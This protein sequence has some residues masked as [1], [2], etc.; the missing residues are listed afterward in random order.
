MSTRV[1]TFGVLLALWGCGSSQP[2]SAVFATSGTGTWR[3]LLP[4]PTPYAENGDRDE[5]GADRVELRA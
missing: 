4:I 2:S 5:N 1:V 3:V